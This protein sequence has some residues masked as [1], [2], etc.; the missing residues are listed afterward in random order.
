MAILRTYARLWV[1]SMD[2]ALPLLTEL[3]GAQPHLRFPLGDVELAA[4]GDFLVIAGTLE[5]QRQYRHASATVV[6]SDIDELQRQLA[7]HGATVVGEVAT[8]ETGSY[9]Y[10]RHA[11]GAEIEYV[12]WSDDL[13]ASL[14]GSHDA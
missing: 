12:Q 5:A 8:G 3:V 14:I 13:V 6:V 9:L 11:D 7:A 10:A 2:D 4:V 1:D